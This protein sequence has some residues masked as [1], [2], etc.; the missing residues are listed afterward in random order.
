MMTRT[1]GVMVLGLT[2]AGCTDDGGSDPVCG[3]GFCSGETVASCPAD[4]SG[5]APVCGDGVC[6]GSESLASCSRDCGSSAC[7]ES[8][9]TCTGE[10]ICITGTCVAAFPRVYRVTSVSVSVPTT[11]PS[12]GSAWDFGGGAP[13]MFLSASG[14]ALTSFVA[15]QFAATFAGPFEVSLVAGQ[16]LRIDVYDDDA[17]ASPEFVTGCEGDP[18]PAAVLR[19]RSFDC[20]GGGVS[21]TSTIRPK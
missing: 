19:S 1:W 21:F 5:S 13:D 10:T 16:G 6:N 12:N 11:N 14:T 15:N 20:V 9:D 8:A 4:C 7:T 3:D 17:P 2:L 18:I